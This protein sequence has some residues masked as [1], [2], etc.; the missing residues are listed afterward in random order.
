MIADM[1]VSLQN[2]KNNLNMLE[3]KARELQMKLEMF[4][5]IEQDLVPCIDMM[6][7][8]DVE[9]KKVEEILKKVQEDKDKIE[10]KSASLRDL[11]MKETVSLWPRSVDDPPLMILSRD[12]QQLKRQTTSAQEKVQRLQRH[13]AM[14]REAA[15]IKFKKLK[16]ELNAMTEERANVQ[17]KID[18]NRRIAEE[19]EFK[20]GLS[21]ITL[22]RS[23]PLIDHDHLPQTAELRKQMELEM[24]A[25]HEDYENLQ[26]QVE[27][28]QDD[29]WLAMQDVPAGFA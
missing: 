20:V 28:Y 17:V 29:M 12:L 16:E 7:E 1:T 4:V 18:Q 6:R 26:M 19:M 25:I 8:V 3:K 9:I 14:K 23:H 2:E 21:R 5:S 27:A 11:M 10:K 15:E 24:A 13:Q 22:L